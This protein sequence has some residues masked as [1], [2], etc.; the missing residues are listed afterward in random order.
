[1]VCLYL[2]RRGWRPHG[3]VRDGLAALAAI[4]GVVPD[5]VLLTDDIPRI[6]AAQ[7]A[8]M[9]RRRRPAVTVVALGE[10]NAPACRVLARTAD[11]QAVLDALAS[12]PGP[13]PPAERKREGLELLGTLTPQ[14]RRVLQLFVDGTPVTEI[15]VKLGVT[16]HTV[17]TH[18]QRLYAKLD[19]HNR[20]EI[21]GFAVRLGLV[22]PTGASDHA[23]G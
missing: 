15:G 13:A 12:R 1:M 14:E 8:T 2:D 20:T 21:I 5:A 22:L 18:L 16:V 7:L 19:C 4:E 23:D 17:R 3:F 11:A 6:G 9:I 10:I